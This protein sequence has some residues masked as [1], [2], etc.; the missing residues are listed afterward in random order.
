[1]AIPVSD[2]SISFSPGI[3]EVIFTDASL[4]TPTSWAWDFGD[5]QTSTVQ[6]PTHTYAADGL[7]T[8]TLVST[9]VDGS[10]TRTR[11]IAVSTSPVLPFSIKELAKMKV[12]SAWVVLDSKYDGF[13]A[14]WQLFIQPLVYPGIPYQ[15]VFEEQAYP[16]LANA[17]IAYL[18]AYSIMFDEMNNLLA[19]SATSSSSGNSSSSSAGGLKSIETGP[20]KVEFHDNTNKV[21]SFFKQG[22]S[23][24]FGN[25][26]G[27]LDILTREIC[28]LASGLGIQLPMCPINPKPVMH[29]KKAGRGP[30]P[31]FSNLK[32]EGLRISI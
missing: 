1:M 16:A 9:N 17:L 21:T 14:M 26:N 15:V 3:L 30:K 22:S 31:L 19:A 8:V 20:S 12:P 32:I 6:N 28:T 7:Y 25:G 13:I 10:H 27:P 23:G 5:S 4:N 11:T 24:V 2:F 18:T 29:F